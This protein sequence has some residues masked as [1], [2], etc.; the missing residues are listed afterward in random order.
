MAFRR[1]RSIRP[2]SRRI[3]SPFGRGAPTIVTDTGNLHLK[4]VWN[5]RKLVNELGGAASVAFSRARDDAQEYWETVAWN[6]ELH[7]Y[8][9]GR[10][11]EAGK[12]E[13]IPTSGNITGQ[14]RARLIGSL[15]PT[16][17][18]MIIHEFGDSHYAGHFPLRMT[19]DFIA[20]RI[21]M[22]LRTAIGEGMRNLNSPSTS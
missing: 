8:M 14:V 21:R 5:G 17:P 22:H 10:E 2:V 6:P 7:P 15:D 1:F 4:Y 20:P 12:F 9:T 11:K 16:E 3:S 19:M 13:V 18:Y